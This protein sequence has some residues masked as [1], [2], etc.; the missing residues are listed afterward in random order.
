MAQFEKQALKA[1]ESG[2]AEPSLVELTPLP[3]HL[4]PNPPQSFQEGV[5]NWLHDS[6]GDASPPQP[7]MSQ[8]HQGSPA[9]SQSAP[10]TPQPQASPQLHPSPLSQ[11][12]Y[13]LPS[14]A[15]LSLHALLY[16]AGAWVDGLGHPC[17][18][19]FWGSSLGL[20][21]A[22]EAAFLTNDLKAEASLNFNTNV[23]CC[24]QTC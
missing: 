18:L 8:A 11:A 24:S 13:A 1:E 16:K 9:V 7:H 15:C 3:D 5:I 19:P 20:L 4:A 12:G 14:L 22:T 17:W 6:S 2:L 21:L 23:V 10:S